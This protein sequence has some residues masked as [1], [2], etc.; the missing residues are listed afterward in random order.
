MDQQTSQMK[1][2][3]ATY[4][5]LII[6]LISVPIAVS[7]VLTLLFGEFEY[8]HAFAIP[9]VTASAIG[10]LLYFPTRTENLSPLNLR[11][12][13]SVVVAG[14][15]FA[16]FISAWPFSLGG[17]VSYRLALFESVSGWTTTGLSVLTEAE[18]PQIYLLWRS[19]MQFLGGAGFAIAM[20]S[21]IIGPIGA[22]LSK[23]EGRQEVL[24]MVKQSAATIGLIYVSYTILAAIG[25]RIFGMSWFDAVNHSMATLST[26]GF[27]TRGASIGFW[28]NPRLEVFTIAVMVLANFNFVTHHNLLRRRWRSAAENPELRVLAVGFAVALGA[29]IAAPVVSVAG[30]SRTYI[31]QIISALTTTGF[32]TVDLSTEWAGAPLLILVILMCIGG[33]VNS[34]SG[35]IKQRR[36]YILF[37]SI[38]WQIREHLLP[39]RAVVSHTISDHGLI[40]EVSD[41]EIRQVGNFV[42]LYLFTLAA[43]TVMIS[44][45]GYSISDS[46]FE[47]ASSVGTVG[48]SV[49]ITGPQAPAGVLWIQKACMFL[50]RLEFFAIIVALRRWLQSVNL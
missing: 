13:M 41:S 30:E 37:K 8:F 20:L 6:L 14:W 34:T 44:A 40:E 25:F 38:T 5:G 42:F 7:A 32:S 21:S 46:L 2:S 35:G 29:V 16:F 48:L 47:A 23:A 50:G 10:C 9:A 12:A 1:K 28:A 45:Y 49:G 36:I 33:G 22:G 39:S 3:S 18:L 43:A 17:L 26:G 4:L 19:L 15:V 11:Q 24:P 27:S 31:F